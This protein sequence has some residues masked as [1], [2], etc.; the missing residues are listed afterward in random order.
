MG[1]DESWILV[2]T[3]RPA[4]RSR[5]QARLTRADER[6]ERR[7]V[8]SQSGHGA[9]VVFILIVRGI[10]RVQDNEGD[11]SGHGHR[12]TAAAAERIRPWLLRP[13]Q[14]RLT[15]RRPHPQ[16]RIRGLWL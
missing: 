2:D 16:R 5:R 15:F 6:G 12:R 8:L 11:I 7:T 3:G 14:Q 4:N 1:T 13:A 10:Q 9:G